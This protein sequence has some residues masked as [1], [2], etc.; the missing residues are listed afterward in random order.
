MKNALVA[1][2]AVTIVALAA[3]PAGAAGVTLT[4][5]DGRVSLD[6]KD[7]TVRQILLEW[8]RVGKTRIVNLERLTSPLLVSLSLNGV[9]ES[10]ALDIVLRTVPGY[11]AAPRATV[12]ADASLYDRILI[13]PT[14]TAVAVSAPIRPQ[15]PTFNDLSPN[16][17]QLRSGP[18]INPGMLP[19]PAPQQQRDANDPA[20]AAATAAG[21]AP[22]NAPQTG[23]PGVINAPVGALQPPASGG[24]ALP[25][26]PQ[27]PSAPATPSNPW[28]APVGASRPGLASPPAPTPS[29]SRPAGAVRPQQADQ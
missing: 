14:T 17:T 4:I 2:L 21:L 27:A 8:A 24:M 15:G 16:V 3:S 11:I 28:N 19:D 1:L 18:T 20:T 25:N 29:P 12:V 7:V 22:L 26:P 5:H 9:P 10:D 6:A 13:V 23:Q